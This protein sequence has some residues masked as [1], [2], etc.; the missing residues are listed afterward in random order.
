MIFAE[1]DLEHTMFETG[2][3]LLFIG[4][5]VMIFC[6][7]ALKKN[8]RTHSTGVLHSAL[9]FYVCVSILSFL[10][11]SLLMENV[12]SEYL[13]FLLGVSTVCFAVQTVPYVIYLVG[14]EKYCNYM[15][16]LGAKLKSHAQ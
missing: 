4:M 10:L 8:S 7:Y 5:L 14:I 9:L 15:K 3:Y 12:W 13:I 1:F 16:E 6:T 2:S 11:R